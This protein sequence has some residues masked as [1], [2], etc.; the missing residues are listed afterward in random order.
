MKILKP[1]R[2]QTGWSVEAAC[3]G[4]GNGMGGCGAILLVEE[5]DLFKTESSCRDERTTFETFRCAA[6]GVLTDLKGVPEKIKG[7]LGKDPLQ[8]RSDGVR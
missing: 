1:G 4:S 7:K 2:E 3:T 8:P 5:T 6:C